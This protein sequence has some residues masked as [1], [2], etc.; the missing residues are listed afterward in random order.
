MKKKEIPSI[1]NHF[2]G[3]KTH[4]KEESFAGLIR[5]YL[6]G[7]ITGSYLLGERDRKPKL[8]LVWQCRDQLGELAE[9]VHNKFQESQT[10]INTGNR[11]V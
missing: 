5:H 6:N 4:D 7:D 2:V 1:I 9:R 11:R 10:K 8:G 3:Q